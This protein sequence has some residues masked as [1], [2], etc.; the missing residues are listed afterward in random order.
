[1]TLPF[2]PGPQTPDSNVQNLQV[3]RAAHQQGQPRFPSFPAQ[4]LH[5]HLDPSSPLPEGMAKTSADNGQPW[6]SAQSD[7]H[8]LLATV[9]QLEHDLQQSYPHAELPDIIKGDASVPAF[10]REATELANATGSYAAAN[11]TV[12]SSTGR[13]ALEGAI[14]VSQLYLAGATSYLT[15]M[16]LRL[17]ADGVPASCRPT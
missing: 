9:S 7:E 14:H 16:T 13:A 4:P 3:L 12:P 17:L 8:P 1:M 10:D 2:L 11:G 6:R 15:S 5:L